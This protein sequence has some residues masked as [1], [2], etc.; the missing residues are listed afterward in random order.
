MCAALVKP[1]YDLVL[2]AR[3]RAV[4]AEYRQL[5]RA[6]LTACQKLGIRQEEAK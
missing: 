6:Y 5:E 1:G 2:V 3:S 4:T